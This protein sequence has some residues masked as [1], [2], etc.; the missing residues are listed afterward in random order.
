MRGQLILDLASGTGTLMTPDGT[1]F[2]ARFPFMTV[3]SVGNTVVLKDEGR[4]IALS[5]ETE[6]VFAGLG[7]DGNLLVC[8]IEEESD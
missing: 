7:S 6:T 2:P 5:G 8:S 1:A 4:T 3:D